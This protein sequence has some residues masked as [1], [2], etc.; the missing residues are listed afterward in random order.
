MKK[1]QREV[2]ADEDANMQFKGLCCRENPTRHNHALKSKSGEPN[3]VRI[4]S[5]S[6]DGASIDNDINNIYKHVITL[7][8]V[9]FR[10]NDILMDCYIC[11]F[12]NYYVVKLLIIL[13]YNYMIV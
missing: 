4:F 9:K 13:I 1:N 2:D 5:H 7:S 8:G 10:Q 12:F 3:P 11:F 6:L